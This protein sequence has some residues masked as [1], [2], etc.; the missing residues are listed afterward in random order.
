M[1]PG[2]F[3]G[4]S[5]GEKREIY[6]RLMAFVAAH[7]LGTRRRI[8][9]ASGGKL[10]VEDVQNMTDSKRVDIRL[11]RETAKA[12]DKIENEEADNEKDGQKRG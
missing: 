12:M 10:T 8:A 9:E 6:A 5:A 1:T 2:A 3:A 11:W 7:G 4:K